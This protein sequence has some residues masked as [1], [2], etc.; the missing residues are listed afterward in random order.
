MTVGEWLEWATADAARR[1]MPELVGLLEGLAPAT[2][3]LR[4]ADWNDDADK[5][6]P[7]DPGERAEAK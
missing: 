1:G 6:T 2:E 4:A 3:R 5:E 7:V